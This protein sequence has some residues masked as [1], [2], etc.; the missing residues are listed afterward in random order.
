MNLKKIKKLKNIVV[1]FNVK[2]EK[3]LLFVKV[4]EKKNFKKKFDFYK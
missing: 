2:N 3:N 4:S 1:L